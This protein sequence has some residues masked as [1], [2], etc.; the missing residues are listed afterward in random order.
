MWLKRLLTGL[1][2]LALPFMGW[3]GHGVYQQYSVQNDRTNILWMAFGQVALQQ[4]QQAR[5]QQVQQQRGKKVT[6]AG[7]QQEDSGSDSQGS[8]ESSE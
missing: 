1:G 3:A 6:P 8:K 2:I 5:L 7:D 4:I